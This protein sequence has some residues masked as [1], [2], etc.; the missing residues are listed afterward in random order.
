MKKVVVMGLAVLAAVVANA[1]SIN[2]KTSL[3]GGAVYSDSSTVLASG[4]A[5]LI[6][7]SVLSQAKLA[8]AIEGGKSFA[9]V[10]SGKTLANAAVSAGKINN[11]F[12]TDSYAAGDSV[13]FYVVVL[14]GNNYYASESVAATVKG[15]GDTTVQFKLTAG[16][17]AAGAWKDATGTGG[18]VPEP[19]SGLLLLVGGAM[20]A[21]RRR[22][23]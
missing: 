21:L 17:K 13:N 20:L 14:N 12:A 5:Y 16:T 7:A 2:W 10:T 23:A 8:S 1:A 3:S 11:T 18:G 4:T 15:V 6:D 19:T 22:R 9:D